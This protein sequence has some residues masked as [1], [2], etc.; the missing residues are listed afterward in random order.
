M[1][2][3]DLDDRAKELKQGKNIFCRRG[4]ADALREVKYRRN[5]AMYGK[6]NEAIEDLEILVSR[7]PTCNPT[8]KLKQ[9]LQRQRNSE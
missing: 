5:H 7:I 1:S 6:A 9:G 3:Q 4:I 2:T 8:P